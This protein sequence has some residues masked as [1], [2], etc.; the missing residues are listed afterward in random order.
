M[1]LYLVHHGDAVASDLDAR[2]PLSDHGRLAVMQLAEQAAARGVKP[3][4]IWHSGKL[5][6]RQTAE[7]FWRACNPL[8][9]FTAIRG[10]QPAD[11]PQ[12]LRDA[13]LGESRDV[14]V[15]GHMP[16][17]SRVLALLTSG[18]DADAPFPLNGMIALDGGATAKTDER[19]LW[20]DGWRLASPQPQAV[21]E[22]LKI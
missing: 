10:L 18:A 13:L 1:W 6:A 2:R 7:A 9:E 5:R 12:M 3:A 11:I 14:M 22:A 15:V 19:A 21:T 20:N 16:H 4:A 8:A 17:L